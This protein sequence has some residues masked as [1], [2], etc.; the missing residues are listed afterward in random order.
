[1]NVDTAKLWETVDKWRSELKSAKLRMA[2]DLF[3]ADDD[4]RSKLE[5]RRTAE[6]AF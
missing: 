4:F 2:V 1:M 5:L 3:F 6:P